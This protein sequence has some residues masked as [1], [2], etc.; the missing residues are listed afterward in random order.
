MALKASP[1][2]QA[3]L[4]DLQAFDTRLAQLDHRAASL[5]ELAAIA[6]LQSRAAILRSTRGEQSGV[7]ENT[8]LELSRLEAD[9]KVV[10]E[11]ITRD[12]SRP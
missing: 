5:P 7:A 1:D 2:K 3:L 9:V 10:E 12:T 4:L 11:R 6:E 8:Q